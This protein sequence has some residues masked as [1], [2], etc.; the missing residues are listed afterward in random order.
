MGD[1]KPTRNP[2]GLGVGLKLPPRVQSRAGLGRLHGCDHGRVFAPPD[3]LP[4]LGL[5][6]SNTEQLCSW[7]T[8]DRRMSFGPKL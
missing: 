2:T 3:P 8:T 7:A 1:P 4:S 5:D 6:P